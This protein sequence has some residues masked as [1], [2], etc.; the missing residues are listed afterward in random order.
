MYTLKPREMC[1]TVK[2]KAHYCLH[3]HYWCYCATDA[4]WVRRGLGHFKV[5]AP[6]SCLLHC[7]SLTARR[8]SAQ[9]CHQ[10][11]S[12]TLSNHMIIYDDL[13]TYQFCFALLLL[14]VCFYEA[15]IYMKLIILRL[16]LQR[17]YWALKP[18]LYGTQTHSSIMSSVYLTEYC[19][20]NRLKK[21]Q[22][23]KK[24]ARKKKEA[25]ALE[26]KERGLLE[27]ESLLDEGDEDLLF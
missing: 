17:R 23:K 26:A 7:W 6:T 2:V 16:K 25:L 18:H 11:Q 22:D 12:G 5:N 8:N 21:I 10:P 4:G 27:P 1:D 9:R 14:C 3:S 24:I 13:M 15:R 19:Y 20:F